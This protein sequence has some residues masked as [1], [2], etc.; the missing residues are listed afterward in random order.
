MPHFRPRLQQFYL[1]PYVALIFTIT[2][3][4]ILFVMHVARSLARVPKPPLCLMYFYIRS[5][6]TTLLGKQQVFLPIF[7][8]T[9][10]IHCQPWTPFYPKLLMTAW[11]PVLETSSNR[12]E[13]SQF[14]RLGIF[15]SQQEQQL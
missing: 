15:Q 5:S 7:F 1:T 11:I 13:E 6:R 9:H 4:F 2:T 10:V 12:A 8:C 3:S 14:A